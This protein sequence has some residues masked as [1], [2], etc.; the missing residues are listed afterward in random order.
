MASN[1]NQIIVDQLKIINRHLI[2]LRKKVDTL[3]RETAEVVVDDDQFRALIRE[4]IEGQFLRAYRETKGGGGKKRGATQD[5]STVSAQEVVN[6]FFTPEM[7]TNSWVVPL[8]NKAS[9]DRKPFTIV[10][11]KLIREFLNEYSTIAYILSN[12]T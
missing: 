6:A 10:L 7:K 5:E 8:P 4:E 11:T 9:K 1:T 2:E 12:I 3:P